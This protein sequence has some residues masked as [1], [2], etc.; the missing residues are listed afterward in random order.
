[1]SQGDGIDNVNDDN[2]YGDAWS[3]IDEHPPADGEAL[4][5]DE[6]IVTGEFKG[7]EFKAKGVVSLM[8]KQTHYMPLGSI[9]MRHGEA[10]P[11]PLSEVDFAMASR[12]VRVMNELLQLDPDAVQWL[13]RCRVLCNKSLADHPTVQVRDNGGGY[14]IGFVGVLNA[15]CGAHKNGLG[16]V[17]AVVDEAGKIER[18]V[19][20]NPAS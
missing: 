17:A 4:V 6:A 11:L 19:V 13:L 8:G 5:I 14:D 1:M 16:A 18:F 9:E 7:G 20:L 3:R 10:T 2:S 15:I 12:A